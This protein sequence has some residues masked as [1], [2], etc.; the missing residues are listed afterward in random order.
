MSLKQ[1]MLDFVHASEAMKHEAR[2]IAASVK[3]KASDTTDTQRA[4]HLQ[5]KNEFQWKRDSVVVFDLAERYKVNTSRFKELWKSYQ[6]IELSLQQQKKRLEQLGLQEVTVGP[7]G[8]G[9]YGKQGSAVILSV[10]PGKKE[11]SIK[12][13]P[14]DEMNGWSQPFEQYAWLL[15]KDIL[16]ILDR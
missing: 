13:Y 6:T 14:Q 9:A 10:A 4:A 11:V 12:I 15:K 8:I 3:S 2:I 7:K 1:T 5:T 16:D